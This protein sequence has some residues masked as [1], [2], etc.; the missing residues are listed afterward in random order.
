MTLL[1]R[2]QVRRVAT[3][4]VEYI[5]SQLSA[6]NKCATLRLKEVIN[7]GMATKAA[8]TAQQ[9]VYYTL[10]FR[11]TPG[12]AV[13][14]AAVESLGDEVRTDCDILRLNAYRQQAGCIHHIVHKKW[15]YCVGTRSA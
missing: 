1:H 2:V 4:T 5:N 9:Y 12:D 13:F 14:Q 11:T 7:A 15:C 10:T 6:Y 3:A 8:V